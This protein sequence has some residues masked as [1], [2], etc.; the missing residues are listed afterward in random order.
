MGGEQEGLVT[1]TSVD[2]ASCLVAGPELLLF[3]TEGTKGDSGRGIL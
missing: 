1:D 2:S 3:H